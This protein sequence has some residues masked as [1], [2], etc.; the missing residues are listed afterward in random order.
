MPGHKSGKEFHIDHIH[1]LT[2]RGAEILVQNTHILAVR[3]QI[4][5]LA[6]LGQYLELLDRLAGGTAFYR[7]A[8]NMERAAAIVAYEGMRRK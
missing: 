2:E 5:R 8:C 6:A 3:K 4:L 7:M 1:V